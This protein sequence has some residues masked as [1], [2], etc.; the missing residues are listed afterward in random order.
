VEDLI[1]QNATKN[2]R[3]AD[4]A[5]TNG[6]PRTKQAAGDASR[7]GYGV[8]EDGPEEGWKC[9]GPPHLNSKLAQAPSPPT[10]PDQQPTDQKHECRYP[11]A[12]TVGPPRGTTS[13]LGS[14]SDPAPDSVPGSDQDST[15]EPSRG[16]VLMKRGFHSPSIE[17]ISILVE[18]ALS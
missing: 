11:P 3:G 10:V 15:S 2:G 14:V 12:T 13:R 16:L 17:M 6:V 7:R 9:P 18:S 1:I 8:E 5:S 4:I